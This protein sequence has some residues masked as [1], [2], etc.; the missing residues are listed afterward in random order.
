MNNKII[1]NSVSND[2]EKYETYT[3]LLEKYALALSNEFYFEAILIVYAMMEDRLKSFLFHIG[4]I[5]DLES[6]KLD[7]FE[8][9]EQLKSIYYRYSGNKDRI[10]LRKISVKRNLINSIL[11]WT[12]SSDNDEDDK[13][14]SDLKRKCILIDSDKF[15]G[16]MEQAENWCNFRN[17]IIHALMNKNIKSI[18]KNLRENIEVGMK[19]AR[20]IDSQVKIVKKDVVLVE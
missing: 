15:S 18:N 20:Y 16:M 3:A 14:L 13:Y 9:R 1:I 5:K 4:A 10:D 8:S 6:N 17:N 2:H 11:K 19:L 7:V 12:N